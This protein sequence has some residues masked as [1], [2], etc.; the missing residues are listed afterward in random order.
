MYYARKPANLTK[1]RKAYGKT[2]QVDGFDLQ[3]YK[4]E[5]H[6]HVLSTEDKGRQSMKWD[7]INLKCYIASRACMA[8]N[9][10]EIIRKKSVR[11]TRRVLM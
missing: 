4:V 1:I 2:V 11:R 3:R 8:D 6:V 10:I 9:G 5:F 7:A